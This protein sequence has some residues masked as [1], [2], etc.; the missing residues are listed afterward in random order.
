MKGFWAAARKFAVSSWLVFV[1]QVLEIRHLWFWSL[2]MMSFIPLT[3]LGF[4]LLF[5]D[6]SPERVIYIVTGSI[7]YS[8]ALQAGL[9]LGQGIGSMKVRRVFD[10][11]ASLPIT[12][13]SFIFGLNLK[14]L[15]L[16]VPS[17]LTLLAIA[18]LAFGVRL[19]N[20]GWLPVAFVLGG[21]S[22]AGLGAAIGFYSRSGQIASIATQIATPI[23]VFFAPV[24]MPEAALPT[25]LRYTAW[26]L[27]TTHVARLL[28]SAFG[29][30]VEGTGQSVVILVGF[31][32]LSVILVQRGLDWR[33]DRPLA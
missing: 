29:E 7:T 2:V 32:I 11:Y 1:S 31:V 25:F 21:F 12:K 20:S 6:A 26:V 9:A 3:M 28:R 14:A 8:V 19:V 33:G 10:Y 5:G 4:L 13:L 23:L 22:L 30:V 15:V 17:T 24:Y 18:L 27:P 16:C